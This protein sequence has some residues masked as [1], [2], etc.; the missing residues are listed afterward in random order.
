MSLL[1]TSLGEEESSEGSSLIHQHLHYSHPALDHIISCLGDWGPPE[2][3]I[4]S[5]LTSS[6]GQS[7]PSKMQIG[8]HGA[9]A[10]NR[11]V[12]SLSG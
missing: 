2:G 12:S 10:Q 1:H 5:S 4:V 8:S 9:P 7:A 11:P 6:R 3:S